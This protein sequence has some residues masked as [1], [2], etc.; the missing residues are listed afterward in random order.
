M[1]ESIQCLGGGGGVGWGQRQTQ[2]FSHDKQALCQLSSIPSAITDIY[3][4]QRGPVSLRSDQ[5]V[6]F[7]FLSSESQKKGLWLCPV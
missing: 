7:L 4:I 3:S 5:T 2:G 1:P 6:V